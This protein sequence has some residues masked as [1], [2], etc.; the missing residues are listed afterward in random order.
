[1]TRPKG[2]WVPNGK[3]EH[4]RK[5]VEGSLKALGVERLFLLQ[6][7]VHDSRVPFEETLAVLAELQKAGKVEH[8]G[9]CNTTVGEI[10]QACRHFTVAVV[11]NELSISVRK[12]RHP[13]WDSCLYHRIWHSVPGVSAFG[14]HCQDGEAGGEQG[15]AADGGQ[16]WGDGGG[17]CVGGGALGGGE[18]D[19]VAGGDESC[20]FVVFPSGDEGA[21]G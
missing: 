20:K 6:L 16:A 5:A 17:D 13:G 9:L 18:C 8:L 12:S 4:I 21:F 15:V 2:K 3:P 14:G 1:M 19:S 10:Q 11:Q 7:H